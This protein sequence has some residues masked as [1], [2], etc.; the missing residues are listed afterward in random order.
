LGHEIGS[1]T[2]AIYIEYD[3]NLV[4]KANKKVIASISSR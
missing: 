1:E 4:D 3:M 2:T